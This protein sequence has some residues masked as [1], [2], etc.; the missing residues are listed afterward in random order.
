[1]K[2]I[3]KS[4]RNFLN[5]RMGG[6]CGGD[7][8]HKK[9][10]IWWIAL[11]IVGFCAEFLFGVHSFVPVVGPVGYVVFHAPYPILEGAELV[12]ELA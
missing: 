11:F 12:L 9:E 6:E 5:F 8:R 2:L 4:R 10:R 1:M 7:S 3:E